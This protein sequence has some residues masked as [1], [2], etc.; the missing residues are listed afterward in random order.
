MTVIIVTAQKSEVLWTCRG[1]TFA[2]CAGVDALLVIG[3]LRHA[4]DSFNIY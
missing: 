3:A 1:G 4:I 2:S